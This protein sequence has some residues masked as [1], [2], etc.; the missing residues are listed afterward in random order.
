MKWL[1]YSFLL[2][3]IFFSKDVSSQTLAND[4]LSRVVGV[5][6]L[7]L[8]N[9]YEF[10]IKFDSASKLVDFEKLF[11]LSKT[12]IFNDVMPDNKL[13]QKVTPFDYA[14]LISRYYTDT[15][16]KEVSIKPYELSSVS[17]E[18]NEFA[19]ISVNAYKYVNSITNVGIEYIDTFNI[20]FEIIYDLKVKSF[21]IYDISSVER[22]ASY[23]QLYPQYRGFLN[24]TSMPNDTILVTGKIF[25]VNKNG[26]TML[27]NINISHEFL[28]VPY[29]NQVFFKMFRVPDNIPFIRNKL[30]DK[31][32]NIVKINFWKWMV[33][34]DFKYNLIPNG[35]SPIKLESDTLGIN[36]V[37]NGSYSN[38]IMM[39]LVRRV[40]TKGYFSFKT[41]AGIDLFTY[42]LNLANNINTYPSVDPD[43]DPYLRINRVYNIQEKH[44]LVYVSVPLVLEKGFTFGKNSVYVQAAY[45]L[46]MNYSALYNLD[47]TAT[48]AGFYDYLFNLTISENGVYD[49]GTYNFEIRNLPLIVNKMIMSYSVGLGY[50]RQLSRKVYFDLGFNYRKSNQY[51]FQENNKALSNNS[52]SI[53]QIQN[54]NHRFGL[55]YF[56]VN[57]G[58]SIKL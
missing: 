9:K 7:D 19:T 30:D 10:I 44:N 26:Y 27:K 28:F 51:L 25:P 56:N 47:A 11:H 38:F 40:S 23:L 55:D 2:L 12:K 54:L 49:F 58:V 41:G 20:R 57:F 36:I 8:I 24:K 42:N 13:N 31:D 43:G 53:N 5:G 48:Y 37:N 15:S 21:A 17:V 46:M 22:R 52:K 29:H 3:A 16:F 45:Y 4:S 1:K 35:V 18:G 6:A 39:N 33:F 14:D 50:N 34:F 32:K